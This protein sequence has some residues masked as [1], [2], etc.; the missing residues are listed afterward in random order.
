ME[1]LSDRTTEEEIAKTQIS[2][3]LFCGVCPERQ[4]TADGSNSCE[5]PSQMMDNVLNYRQ[6]FFWS[7]LKLSLDFKKA[8]LFLRF[9][10]CTTFY[11]IPNPLRNIM[12]S[13]TE[14]HP[15]SFPSKW[16]PPHSRG[17]KSCDQLD[18]NSWE[19]WR[20]ESQYI[21]KNLRANKELGRIN[22]L[23]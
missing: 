21:K 16:N 7:L 8:K 9:C 14:T 2:T 4:N 11:A 3:F 12:E 15:P 6:S 19:F 22:T 17:D 18:R 1:V 20:K 5:Y 13:P 23:F 10:P